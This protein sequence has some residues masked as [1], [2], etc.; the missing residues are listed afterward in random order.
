MVDDEILDAL[1]LE[2]E[3]RIYAKKYGISAL[4]D[5]LSNRH[6]ND[7][8]MYKICNERGITWQEYFRKSEKKE[9]GVLI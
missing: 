6:W 1:E 9:E 5:P 4:A 2:G 8:E 3:R 7:E